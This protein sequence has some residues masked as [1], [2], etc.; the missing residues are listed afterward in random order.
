MPV[1]KSRIGLLE[2]NP[3]LATPGICLDA[4]KASG[5]VLGAKVLV[6]ESSDRLGRE[7]WQITAL[8]MRWDDVEAAN[9]TEIDVR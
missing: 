4:L 3:V 6:A 8:V 7:A 1:N 2:N 9:S 5:C